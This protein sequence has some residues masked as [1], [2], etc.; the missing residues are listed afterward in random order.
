MMSP[1]GGGGIICA[2]RP[3]PPRGPRFDMPPSSPMIGAGRLSRSGPHRTL[4]AN[5]NA[6]PDGEKTVRPQVVHGAEG[7]TDAAV[8]RRRRGHRRV[9]VHRDAAVEVPRA[10]EL[11]ERARVPA[12]DG[13]VDAVRPLRGHRVLPDAVHR[14][15][16]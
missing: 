14:V 2:A 3:P 6:T 4:S 8:R 10:V 13:A 9:A 7:D 12:V 11:T 15:V 1:R 5:E 16:R